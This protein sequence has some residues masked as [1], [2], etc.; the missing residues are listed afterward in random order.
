MQSGCRGPCPCLRDGRDIIEHAQE[1]KCPLGKHQ[2]PPSRGL[3]DTIAKVAHAIGADQAAHVFERVTGRECG[4]EK[5]REK[6]NVLIRY[7][8]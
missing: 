8:G 5:R 1:G 6:L 2:V 4:C 7:S 3:G